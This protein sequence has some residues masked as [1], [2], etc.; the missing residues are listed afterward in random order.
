MG[1]KRRRASKKSVSIYTTSF[2]FRAPFQ[3]LVDGNFLHAAVGSLKDQPHTLDS[4]MKKSLT[5]DVRLFT[6]NCVLAELRA[7]GS[8]FRP[9]L[10]LARESCEVRKCS[11]YP[12]RPANECFQGLIGDCNFHRYCIATLDKPLRILLRKVKATPLIYIDR[13]VMILEPP[14]LA[15]IAAVQQI[16]ASKLIP[17]HQRLVRVPVENDEDVLAAQKR[18]RPKAPNPLSCKKKKKV[19]ETKVVQSKAE[20]EAAPKRKRKRRKQAEAGKQPVSSIEAQ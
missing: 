18:K 2:G 19:K 9:A 17:E 1:I 3:V 11:H 7:L 15:T 6:T 5:V 4:L 20:V 8:D 13:S 10:N 14:S 16:E 12:P